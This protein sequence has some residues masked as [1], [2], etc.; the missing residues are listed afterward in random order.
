MGCVWLPR[1]SLGRLGRWLLAAGMHAAS[2]AQRAPMGLDIFSDCSPRGPP[3]EG[4]IP[5]T[6]ITWM[7]HHPIG[8]TD[9]REAH[10]VPV[11]VGACRC[12]A[13]RVVCLDVANCAKM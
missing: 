4:R 5:H 13:D 1:H 7:H 12:M 6:R 11:G 2:D 9:Q 10:A 8:I 3:P